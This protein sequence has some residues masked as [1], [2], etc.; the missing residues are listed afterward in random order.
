MKTVSL[1]TSLI[2]PFGN[3]C[4]STPNNLLGVFPRKNYYT[5][6]HENTTPFIYQRVWLAVS[7][8]DCHAGYFPHSHIYLF[9]TTL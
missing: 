1:L 7:S 6:E 9:F 3:D 4:T 2:L 8:L 5:D